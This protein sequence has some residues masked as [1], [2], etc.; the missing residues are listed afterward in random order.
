MYCGAALTLMLPQTIIVATVKLELAKRVLQML[1]N[2]HPV[3]ALDAFQL[4]NWAATPEYA[5]LP[6]GE[7]AGRILSEE[8]N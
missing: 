4:R 1:A 7:I 3:P 8:E 5:M 2:G 6:L